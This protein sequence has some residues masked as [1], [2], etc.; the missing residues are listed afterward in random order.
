MPIDPILHST[1]T[2]PLCG[3]VKTETMPT[4]AC[5]WF[6]DCD[7]CKAVLKPKPGDCCVF[8]SYADVPC[9]PVQIDGKHACCR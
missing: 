7:G 4:N 3:H 9:P 2:C 6:Y 8:C 5:Q 1:L